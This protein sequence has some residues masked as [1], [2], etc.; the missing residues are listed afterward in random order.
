MQN[1]AGKHVLAKVRLEA[2]LTQGEL[3]ARVGCHKMSIQR[4]EQGLMALSVS[5]A[6]RIQEKLGVSSAWLLTNDF[7][8][9]EITPEGRPWYKSDFEMRQVR[10][11]TWGKTVLPSPEETPNQLATL[12]EQYKRWRLHRL[13]TH[14]DASLSLAQKTGRFNEFGLLLHRLEETNSDIISHFGWDPEVIEA[15]KQKEE[16]LQKAYEATLAA[17]R[18]AHDSLPPPPRKKRYKHA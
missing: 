9:V 18:P 8:A 12:T 5:L 3:A 15:G 11:S 16:E 17:T 6:E 7:D 4:I 1:S 14:L 13:T 10:A 2:G